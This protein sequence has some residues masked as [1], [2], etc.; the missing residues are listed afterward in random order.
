[1]RELYNMLR[2]DKIRFK[3]KKDLGKTIKTIN[4]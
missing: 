4:I 2:T 1:M 3:S